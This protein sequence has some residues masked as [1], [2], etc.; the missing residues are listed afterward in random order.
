MSE[1]ILQAKDINKSF[2]DPVTVPVLKNISFEIYKG[3]F[4]R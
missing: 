4:D 3:E 1:I 2:H